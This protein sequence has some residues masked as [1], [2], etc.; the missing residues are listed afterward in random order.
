[1][2]VKTFPEL[3]EFSDDF[4]LYDGKLYVDFTRANPENIHQFEFT[5]EGKSG[6]WRV[7]YSHIAFVN[8]PEIMAMGV[9]Q[10]T[11]LAGRNL[12]CLSSTPPTTESATGHIM[13]ASAFA[14]IG[15]SLAESDGQVKVWV[16][17][18]VAKIQY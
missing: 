16:K 11:T 15:S 10:S 14:L 2:G 18:K 5:V 12:V 7:D 4:I 13:S 1:M 17:G 8:P 3:G 9:A 6:L